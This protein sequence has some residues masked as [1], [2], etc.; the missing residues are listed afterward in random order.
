MWHRLRKR[1]Y[2]G[3]VRTSAVNDRGQCAWRDERE[4]HQKT[5]VPFHLAFTRR[6]P[7]ERLNA[8]GYDIAD[9]GARLSCENA[10]NDDPGSTKLKPLTFL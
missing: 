10:P 1:R 8:A 3:I 5:N 2:G 9:P 4:R 6:D 7:G